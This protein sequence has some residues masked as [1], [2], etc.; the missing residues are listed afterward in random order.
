VLGAQWPE[1]LGGATEAVPVLVLLDVH[2]DALGQVL[3]DAGFAED[4]R[5]G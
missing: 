1:D 5:A 3:D 2:D 4:V